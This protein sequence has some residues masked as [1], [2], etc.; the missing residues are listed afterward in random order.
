M[1]KN[2]LILAIC[3]FVAFG[4]TSCKEEKTDY[5]IA[6]ENLTTTKGWTLKTATCDPAY[7]LS[8]DAS[9]TDLFLG[10]IKDCELDDYLYFNSNNS[11]L[12]NPGKDGKTTN[13]EYLC[14][15]ATEVAL[16]N[17]DLSE[18]MKTLKFYLPYYRGALLEATV[19]TLSETTLT[20][21]VKIAEDDGVDPSKVIRN[22]TFNL[23]YTRN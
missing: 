2:I 20:L 10:Y 1:K 9:I 18:D 16:G 23:S 8:V 13:A 3:A 6:I 21:N 11:Q 7:E 15:D 19:L 12:L 4:F 14:A 5:E 22:Y 17:W